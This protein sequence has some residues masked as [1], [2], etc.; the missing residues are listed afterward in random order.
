MSDRI[1]DRTLILRILVPGL[2]ARL[3]DKMIELED[4][5]KSTAG[6]NTGN[7][8][9]SASASHNDHHNNH[10][11]NNNNNNN[12][13]GTSSATKQDSFLDL[14]GVTCEPTQEGSTLWNFHC[15]GATYP[16]RLVN[17]PCPV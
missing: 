8:S 5:V 2:E 17:L 15:D 3:R 1:R 9:V 16:A 10:H 6:N 4:S 12:N 14:E 7:N 13:N 11:H